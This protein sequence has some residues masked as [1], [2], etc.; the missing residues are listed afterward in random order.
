MISTAV[1]ITTKCFKHV[2]S[3]VGLK[4][5]YPIEF[6][7]NTSHGYILCSAIPLEKPSFPANRGTYPDPATKTFDFPLTP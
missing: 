1:E 7:L 6:S 3:A 5:M 4:S 2:G